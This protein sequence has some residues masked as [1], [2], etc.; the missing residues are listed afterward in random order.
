[1]SVNVDGKIDKVPVP[2]DLPVNV[3]W[4]EQKTN[5]NILNHRVILSI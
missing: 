5:M 3:Y 1:M 2:D 4:S